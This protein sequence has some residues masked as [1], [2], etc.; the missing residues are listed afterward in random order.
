MKSSLKCFKNDEV[1]SC[2]YNNI[3]FNYRVTFYS[4][5]EYVHSWLPPFFS[6]P[7]ITSHGYKIIESLSYSF[8][9]V[10]CLWVSISEWL[11]LLQFFSF[12]CRQWQFVH[13]ILLFI[14]SMELLL[15]TWRSIYIFFLYSLYFCIFHTIILFEVLLPGSDSGLFLCIL[16]FQYKIVQI[17]RNQVTSIYFTCIWSWR[18]TYS[19]VSNFL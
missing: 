19:S 9:V 13:Q 14:M 10:S 18:F 12:L 3:D 1:G 5:F 4:C 15:M 7:F 11:F 16:W 2:K 8:V 17:M 6:L